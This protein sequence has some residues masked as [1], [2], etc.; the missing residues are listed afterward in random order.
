[1]TSATPGSHSAARNAEPQAAGA[2][3]AEQRASAR[4]ASSHS[5]NAELERR[6][7]ARLHEVEPLDQRLHVVRPSPG[8]SRSR[9]PPSRPGS[10]R[11]AGRGPSARSRSPPPC[12]S[13]RVVRELNTSVDPAE[14]PVGQQLERAGAAAR[15]RRST[16]SSAPSARR[17]SSPAPTAAASSPDELAIATR[18]VEPRAEA[19][20]VAER[21]PCPTNA[22][23]VRRPPAASSCW[24]SPLDAHVGGPPAGVLR[25]PGPSSPGTTSPGASS[26]RSTAA[27]Q[28]AIRARLGSSRS[29]GTRRRRRASRSARPGR[30]RATSAAGRSRRRVGLV[31]PYG[32]AALSMR[33][34]S[35]RRRPA[36]GGTRSAP[37]SALRIRLRGRDQER[38]QRQTARDAHSPHSMGGGTAQLRQV[39]VLE[40]HPAWRRRSADER[41][42][43]KRE[44]AAACDDFAEDHFLRTYSLVGTRG[45]ADLMVRGVAPSLDPIHELHV[46]I[47]QSGLMRWA[48]IAHSY[49]AM[50]KE[51]AYSDEP[52]PLEPR[53]GATARYL[54]VYPM[55]KKREWYTLPRRGADADHEGPHRDRPPIRRNRDQHRLLLWPGR[56]GVR[57]VVQRGRPGRVPGSRARAAGYGVEHLH[58]LETPIFTCIRSA[59][60]PTK[61]LDAL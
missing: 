17:S 15:A 4:A 43:D 36:A 39:H 11:R 60:R 47:N 2:P 57:R 37:R 12:P 35:P 28:P 29:D 55:W 26:A 44:F 21:P 10:R 45:D 9:G 42:A 31:T 25:P 46:L 3:R 40:G 22:R 48:D 41:A 33:S 7:A 27:A 34:S 56:P 1:M 13:R 20:R 5:P 49:L 51:S 38:G 8:A 58:A 52:Q 61:A 23:L 19:A 50:T 53:P 54:F 24:S 16:R 30:C 32:A 18:C 6:A 14:A 59:R